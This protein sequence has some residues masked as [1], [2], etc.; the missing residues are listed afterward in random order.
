M[1]ALNPNKRKAKRGG[2]ALKQAEEEEV[3]G[4][5]RQKLE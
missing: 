1:W 4:P 2:G 3:V 5:N